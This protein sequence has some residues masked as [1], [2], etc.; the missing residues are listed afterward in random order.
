VLLVSV[1]LGLVFSL[2]LDAVLRNEVLARRLKSP[3]AASKANRYY[4]VS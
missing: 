2:V 3:A 4:L 1:V